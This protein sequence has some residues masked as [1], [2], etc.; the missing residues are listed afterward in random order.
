MFTE[1]DSLPLGE[2]RLEV[3]KFESIGPVTVV[4]SSKDLEDLKDLVDFTVSHEERF[5]LSHLC[6]Y[7]SS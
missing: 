3:W 6:K 4:G 1:W 2:S 5:L 7:T